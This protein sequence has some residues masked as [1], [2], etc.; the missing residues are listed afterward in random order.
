MKQKRLYD[1]VRWRKVAKRHLDGD[2]LCVTCSK[3]GRVTPATCVDHII[4]H[5]GDPVLF[6]DE[7]NFQSLCGSC[8]S[9][10][11]RV[12]EHHGYS[13][14]CD[15]NGFPLDVKHPFFKE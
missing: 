6:W 5:K 13:Q 7:N 14:A 11:K 12:A 8:H 10:T 15:V 4:P 9:G 2:P 1:S 3:A